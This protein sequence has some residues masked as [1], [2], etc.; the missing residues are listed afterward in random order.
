MILQK[1]IA[2]A[3]ARYDVVI[4]VENLNSTETNF[5]NTLEEA[6]E[7][8][9]KV[10]HPNLRLCADI[11][12]MLKEGESPAIIEKAGELVVHCDLAE[13]EKRT[14]PGVKGDDFKPYLRALKKI[15]Y[16]GVIILECQ[17]ESL[18]LQGKPAREY[19]EKQLNEAYK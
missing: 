6:Y 4:A 16:K 1:K 15:K 13:K 14:P 12:H 8:I 18:S 19:L 11:Y 2:T 9:K 10:N 5:I 3:A 7:V 17:W